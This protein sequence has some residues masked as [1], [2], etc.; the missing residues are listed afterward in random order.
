LYETILFDVQGPVATI[1]L[2]R[3]E[4]LNAISDR[5]SQELKHAL[6]DAERN[7]SV[8]GIV[9]TGAG[10]GFSAGADMNS[11]QQIQAAGDL[12]AA[13]SASPFDRAQPGD[14]SMGDEYGLVY[15]Y[16]LTVR[17]PIIAAINGP[18]AGLGFSL[19]C[20]CDLRFMAENAIYVTSYSNRGLVAEHGTSWILPRLLGPSRALDILWSSRRLGAAEALSLGL[21]NR[22]VPGEQLVET[23][24]EYIRT[25]AATAAPFSLR[26]MKWQIYRHLMQPLGESMRET[27]RM[28]AESIKRPDFKE[29]IASFLERRPPAFSHAVS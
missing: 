11:L 16:L 17:K 21:A 18:C 24:Q 7:E 20:F 8:V 3:P 5:M 22:V 14:P 29:G 13:R 15:A 19:A 27:E 9:I 25:L 23:A 6:A 1:T 2:N 4:K 10:R 12:G 28:M 26:S